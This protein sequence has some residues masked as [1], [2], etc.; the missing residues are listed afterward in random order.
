M[1]NV[2]R[3]FAMIDLAG[4][5]A[6]TEA[7]GDDQA[8]DVAMAF[9]ELARDSLGPADQLVK[10]IGDAVLL[11]SPDPTA[12]LELVSRTLAA[13]REINS[14]LVTRTGL[15]HGFVAER[16]DDYF[17]ATV[18]LTARLA[19]H[20]GGSQVLATLPIANAARQLG[21]VVEDLG[22][23]AFKN[24][25][26]PTRVFALDFGLAPAAESVDPVCRMRVD[27]RSAA[28]TLRHGGV[29]YWF[30]SLECAGRFARDNA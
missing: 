4:F 16:A 12:G 24:V 8:A 19:A 28:G 21:V 1:S 29:E 13:C 2:A 6:L 5:T 30:C 26:E 23:T 11:A 27:H 22:D 3:T 17:G 25:A 9:S 14:F 18:N 20:A 7:H 15:H 10:T